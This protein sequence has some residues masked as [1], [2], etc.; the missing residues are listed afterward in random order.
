M[1]LSCRLHRGVTGADGGFDP[2]R[3]CHAGH[4][5]LCANACDLSYRDYLVP[6]H[7]IYPGRGLDLGLDLGLGLGRGGGLDHDPYPYPDHGLYRSGGS[8]LDLYLDPCLD[9]C[10]DPFD[11]DPDPDP[12]PCPCPYLLYA[13]RNP[14]YVFSGPRPAHPSSFLVYSC[15]SR[16]QVVLVALGALV[17][18]CR[19]S[20][21]EILQPES[22]QEVLLK[23]WEERLVSELVDRTVQQ[24]E[25]GEAS[26]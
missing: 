23:D 19:A 12:D 7:Q 9:P 16:R 14:P 1:F 4:H 17:A 21:S 8:H 10:L 15:W 24:T 3:S 6:Y 20:S 18:S 13:P 2:C 11:S 22:P 25:L 26:R 5:S